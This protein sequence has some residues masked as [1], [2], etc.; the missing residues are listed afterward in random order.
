MIVLHFHLLQDRADRLN[1]YNIFSCN[2]V[3]SPIPPFKVMQ[4]I[5]LSIHSAS[6]EKPPFGNYTT[7]IHLGLVCTEVTWQ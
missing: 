2:M 3:M 5:Y 4:L 7:L 6:K 1:S